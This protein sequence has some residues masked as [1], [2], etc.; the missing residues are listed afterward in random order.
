M[1]IS[2][3]IPADH[4]LTVRMFLT[5][6]LMV[7]LYARVI[8]ILFAVGL[9]LGIRSSSSPAA[10]L[11]LPVLVLRQ[12]RPLRHGRARSSPPSRSPSCTASSTGSAPWPT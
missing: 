3:R 1:A 4:G 7:L 12:D 8:G 5:G 6:L 2:R 11:V 9:Q 10:L